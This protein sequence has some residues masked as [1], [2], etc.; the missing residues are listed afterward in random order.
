MKILSKILMALAVLYFFAIV[1]GFMMGPEWG[2]AAITLPL[3][4]FIMLDTYFS[5]NSKKTEKL[6]YSF[7]KSKEIPRE[8]QIKASH[9]ICSLKHL[10]E[11]KNND[12]SLR[13]AKQ[14]C[15]LS[16]N[17]KVYFF[18]DCD[19]CD[20][21]PNSYLVTG[22]VLVKNEK[23]IESIM[24]DSQESEDIVKNKKSYTKLIP[25]VKQLH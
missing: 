15:N 4:P 14:F 3:T 23:P 7:F 9:A 20:L 22:Y 6:K 5:L 19:G 13:K 25:I 8:A 2:V 24:I 1:I 10:N 21:A 12:V 18:E 16:N 17:Y 11:S